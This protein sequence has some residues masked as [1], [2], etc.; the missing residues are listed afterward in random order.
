MGQAFRRMGGRVRA[1][2]SPP[3]PP[4]SSLSKAVGAAPE[5]VVRPAPEVGAEV[6]RQGSVASGR[7]RANMDDVQGFNPE[8]LL[9]ER[10]A[11][12]DAMLSQMVGRIRSKPGGMPEMGEAS[13]VEKY[14]RP[15]P[16]L[17]NTTPDSGRLE[18]RPVAPGTLNVA[19]VKQIILLYQGKSEGQTGPMDTREIAEKFRV[20]AAHVE[21]IV[22]FLSL[23]QDDSIKQ[24]TLI[25]T[26]P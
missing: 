4:P 26:V 23:P 10:D 9:E 13:V 25:N 12:Y 11:E 19:Q 15:L 1:M 2:A 20:D 18:D 21:R 14:K 3:P 24:K 22:Q 7:D 5:R 8:N 17:R 6:S 16:K